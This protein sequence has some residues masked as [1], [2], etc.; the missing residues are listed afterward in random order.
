MTANRQ[1]IEAAFSEDVLRNGANSTALQLDPET[2][3]VIRD[4]EHRT[5]QLQPL[6]A[7]RKEIVTRLTQEKAAAVAKQA[8]EQQLKTLR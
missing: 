1:V 3:V 2:L 5:P 6:D 8:G 4:K 7:V